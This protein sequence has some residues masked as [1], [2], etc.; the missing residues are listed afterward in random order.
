[1]SGTKLHSEL[2]THSAKRY[3]L[4]CRTDRSLSHHAVQ[5]VLPDQPDVRPAPAILMWTAPRVNCQMQP[6]S[7]YAVTLGYGLRHSARQIGRRPG[8]GRSVPAYRCLP[9]FHSIGGCSFCLI[10]IPFRTDGDLS[11]QGPQVDPSGPLRSNDRAWGAAFGTASGA[12]TSG[13]W[14]AP[15]TAST[16]FVI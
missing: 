1:M 6:A 9:A 16:I 15:I 12:C 5:C 10:D 14:H 7:R 4:N 8:I 11:G 2:E 3:C 13:P